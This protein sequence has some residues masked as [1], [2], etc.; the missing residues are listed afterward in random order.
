MHRNVKTVYMADGGNVECGGCEEGMT[1]LRNRITPLLHT[2]LGDM[3]PGH[4]QVF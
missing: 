3:K 2:Y 4:G 1:V